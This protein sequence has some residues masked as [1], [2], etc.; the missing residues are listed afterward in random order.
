MTDA[1]FTR[2]YWGDYPTYDEQ[3]ESIKR[4]IEEFESLCS[5]IQDTWESIQE[6]FKMMVVTPIYTPREYGMNLLKKKQ[7]K[8]DRNRYSY[9]KTTE[10]NL[11]Y[12]RRCFA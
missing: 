12:M 9:M 6:A 5:T 3:L 10:K 1:C 7:S 4:V 2:D 11:P 8:N